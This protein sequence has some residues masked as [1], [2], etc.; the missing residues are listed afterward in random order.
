MSNKKFQIFIG[1]LVS[2]RKEKGETQQQIADAL[3]FSRTGYSSWEQGISQPSLEDLVKLCIHFGVSSDFLLGL[4]STRI[5]QT[6]ITLQSDMI[7]RNPLDDLDNDLRSKAEG[8]I[9]SLRD[10]QRERMAAS[11]K[12]A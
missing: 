12:E 3:S 1:R 5:P 4:S 2:L 9:E 11:S 7:Q 10:I 8:Y 6:T